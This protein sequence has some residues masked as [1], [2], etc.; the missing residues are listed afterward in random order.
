MAPR[1]LECCMPLDPTTAVTRRQHTC[2]T[3][4]A[5]RGVAL[6]GVLW[7]VLW[8]AGCESS[9]SIVGSGDVACIGLGMQEDPHFAYQL[10]VRNVRLGLLFAP[11]IV[12]P[13]VVVATELYCPV[14][15]R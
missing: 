13:V 7:G 1:L 15:R 11:T 8:M 5:L 3:G 9:R 12:P 14:R 6:V 10:S 4:G 2:K